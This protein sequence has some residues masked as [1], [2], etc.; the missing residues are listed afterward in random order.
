MDER[1]VGVFAERLDD[2]LGLVVPEEAVVDED[3]GQVV[4]DGPV[5]EHRRR[6]RIDPAGEPAHRPRVPD[7]L[8][9]PLYRI[10]DD[11]D[12][13]PLGLAAAGLVQ[14]VLE[15]LHPV[16]RVPDLGME[17]DP[18]ASFVR[19]LEGDDGHRRGLGRDL[20]ALRDGENGVPV[21]RPGLLL[22]RRAGEEALV[23][24]D[25]QIRAAVLPDLDGPHLPALH[26]AP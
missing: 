24:L 8:P 16:L 1:Y 11:V 13:R 10:G 5:H 19:V 22:V 12:R 15:Y 14:E 17:L 25:Q 9:Y 20:E 26:A 23:A 21:A 6:R 2:L 4:P 7:L 3:A 18:E